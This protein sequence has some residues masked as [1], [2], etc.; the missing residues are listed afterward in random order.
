MGPDADDILRSFKLSDDDE[1][2]Y[3]MVK[4]KFESHFVKRRN[5]IF[6]RGK[7]NSQRQE[8]GEPVDTFITDLY[9]LAVHCQ[10]G[11]LHDELIRD[12]LVVGIHD[13]TLSEKLQ[14]DAKLTLDKAVTA[15]H[16]SEAI[17][18]QQSTVRGENVKDSIPSKIAIHQRGGDNK[19]D[20]Q[21]MS[22]PD[23]SV[24]GADSHTHKIT[25]NAQHEMLPVKRATR[26]DTSKQCVDHLLTSTK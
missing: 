16:Q 7:F 12:N 24:I 15:V 8:E 19:R 20:D 21:D 14:L 2:K 25:H 17:K 6:E 26:K 5:V 10:Y 11:E 23:P 13:E 9:T 18:S 22:V 1:K 4:D 3:D